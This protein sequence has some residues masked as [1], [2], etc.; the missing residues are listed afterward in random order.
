MAQHPV[1]NPKPYDRIRIAGILTPGVCRRVSGGDLEIEGQVQQQPGFIGQTK[2]YKLIKLAEIEYEFTLTT[3]QDVSEW[4]TLV[5]RLERAMRTT[6]TVDP[7]TATQVRRV[8]A[9]T[10]TDPR[11][12]RISKVTV[13]L[14]GAEEQGSVPGIVKHKLKLTEWRK[15]VRLPRAAASPGPQ[16]LIANAEAARSAARADEARVDQAAAASATRA[17]NAVRRGI[18]AG[19]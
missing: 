9:V 5:Q 3:D 12:P 16:S 17:A 11:Y 2:V 15:T 6:S 13:D 14:I 1:N 19:G 4:D 8:E 18:A 10:L 7:Q